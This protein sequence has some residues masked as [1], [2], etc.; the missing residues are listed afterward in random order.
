MSDYQASVSWT[1]EGSTGTKK[2]VNLRG[3]CEQLTFAAECSSGSTG[4]VQIQTRFGSSVGPWLT[5]CTLV[6]GTTGVVTLNSTTSGNY[7]PLEWIRPRLTDM[8]AG[9]TNIIT[10]YVLG[11]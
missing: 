11:N 8:T 6:M 5:L 1:F 2:A 9:S 3:R 7:G 10:V 4:N